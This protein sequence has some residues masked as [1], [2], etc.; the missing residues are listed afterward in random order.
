MSRN[1]R[2]EPVPSSSLVRIVWEGGGEMPA[3]LS[4]G[5][6]TPAKAK[7]AI[8]AWTDEQGREVEVVVKAEVTEAELQA[9]RGPGRPPGT[10][11]K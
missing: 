5:Y 10:P 6:T 9:R 11:N 7:E 8:A 3:K 2:I 1:F 4:G